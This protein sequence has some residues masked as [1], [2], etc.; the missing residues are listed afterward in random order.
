MKQLETLQD[1]KHF[2]IIKREFKIVFTDNKNN[3]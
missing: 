3:N 2:N 1:I